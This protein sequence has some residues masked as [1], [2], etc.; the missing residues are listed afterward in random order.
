MRSEEPGPILLCAGQYGSASTWLYNAAHA[1]LAAA[2]GEAAVH[3]Q[4]ADSADDLPARPDPRA[5]VLKSHAPGA[6]LR[7]LL[8][9]GGGKAVLTLRDPR[10]AAASLLHRFGFDYP[11]VARR[12]AKSGAALPLLLDAGFPLLVLR[13]EDGFA[14]RRETLDGLAA[15]LGL[16][17]GAAVLD[18]VF[19]ALTPDAVRRD[20]ARL[21]AAG[22][23]GAA[24]TAHSHDGATHWHPG[25]VGDGAVG[26]FA[27][28]LTEGQQGDIIRRTRPYQAAFDYPMP[29]L[30]PPVPG[31]AMPVAGWGPGMAHLGPG[32][33]EPQEEGAWTEGVEARLHLAGATGLVELDLELPRPR[34]RM[35]RNPMSWSLWAEHGAAPLHGPIEAKD[36]PPH[37]RVAVRIA[38]GDLLLRFANLDVAKRVGVDPARRLFGLRLRGF[39]LR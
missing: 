35:P 4:F 22:A 12:V 10:D 36:T 13:Y 28:V 16:S 30:A 15:F 20:I 27:R 25:H 29:P 5:L 24:P 26:K 3:R 1:L 31:R 17:P 38:S 6:S 2:W 7:W 9:R 18:A 19:A 37:Q 39:T 8:A 23:F 21:E 11:L 33:A 14:A 32:F 34:A